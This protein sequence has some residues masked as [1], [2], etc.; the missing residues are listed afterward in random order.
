MPWEK[1]YSETDVLDRAILAFW[2]RGYQ[3]TSMADL[4]EATGINRGSIY[5][6]F[7]DK[8]GLFLRTLAHYDTKHRSDFLSDVA[9]ND[10]PKGAILTTFHRVAEQPEDKPGGCLLV[11]TALELSPH[12]PEIAEF[13]GD[14]LKE[15]ENF[16]CDCIKAAKQNGTVRKGLNPRATAQALLGLFLGVRVL[17][18]AT[19]GQ[20]AIASIL[21]QVDRMLD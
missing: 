1:S 14:R 15:I 4:V 18:R 8:R 5:A 3:A 2:A 13:V 6:A 21:K 16:F 7:D 20:K 19:P 9:R 11:N 12:D 17:S 10:D